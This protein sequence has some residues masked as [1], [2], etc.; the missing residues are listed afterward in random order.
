MNPGDPNGGGS[1]RKT[2]INSCEESLRRLQ[3]DYMDLY[4]LHDLTPEN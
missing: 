4:W 3:T 1:S 2:I